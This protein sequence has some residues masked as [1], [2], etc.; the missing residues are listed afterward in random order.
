MADMVDKLTQEQISEC[1]AAFRLFDKDGDGTITTQE[2]GIIMRSLGQNP[3][4]IELKN[5]IDEVDA[6]GDGTV[7]FHE[8]LTMMSK[9]LSSRDTA[10]E[11]REAFRVFDKE[12]NGFI[13]VEELRDIMG[14][15]GEKMTEEEVEE[16]IQEVDI[17]GDGRVYCDE[18]VKM[19]TT[20]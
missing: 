12:A 16:M 11:I 1:R 20:K 10:G 4:D 19:L 15:M 14:N 18:F 6:D 3:T 7:D 9:Q 5:I 13:T 17:D 2:L 8:F